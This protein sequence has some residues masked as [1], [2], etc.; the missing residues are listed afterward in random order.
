MRNIAVLDSH[1]QEAYR[2][3]DEVS[4]E[5]KLIQASITTLQPEKQKLQ[6]QKREALLWLDHWKNRARPV[7]SKANGFRQTTSDS[8]EDSLE[9]AEFTL[10]DLQSAT[11][12]LSESFKIG[13]GG[14]AEVY[15][16]E[17]L[18]RTVAIKK[19]HPHNIQKQPEFLHEVNFFF[20]LLIMI[21]RC[22]TKSYVQYVHVSS[23]YLIKVF[24][25]TLNHL[26]SAGPNSWPTTPSSS[27]VI[28]WCMSRS[29]V[30]RL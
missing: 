24:C 3:C 18:G 1:A 27:G 4:G 22:L 26:L 2:R 20:G 15:K 29:L 23:T 16:G 28:N 25:I 10:S 7:V 14:S 9:L 21:L 19:L 13:Q 11:C 5:L 30:P 12:D 6:R 8:V 17:M